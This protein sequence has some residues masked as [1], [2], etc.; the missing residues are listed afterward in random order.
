[1]HLKVS[2]FNGSTFL[3]QNLAKL[4]WKFR[5]WISFD[6]FPRFVKVN[7]NGGKLILL[8]LACWDMYRSFGNPILIMS[9]FGK[10]SVFGSWKSFNLLSRLVGDVAGDGIMNVVGFWA[11]GMCIAVLLSGISSYPYQF[12]VS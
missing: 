6:E 9:Q 5:S 7:N 4:V 12:E 2:L 10:S 11:D 1:M 3:V 8:V